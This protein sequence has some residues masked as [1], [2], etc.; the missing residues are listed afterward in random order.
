MCQ[1]D[2]RLVISTFFVCK[3]SQLTYLKICCFKILVRYIISSVKFSY[4]N[5]QALVVNKESA[6]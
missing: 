2:C 5:F 1:S 4:K 6:Q 3:I